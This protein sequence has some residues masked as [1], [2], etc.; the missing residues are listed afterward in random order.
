MTIRYRSIALALMLHLLLMAE[1]RFLS[2]EDSAAKDPSGVVDVVSLDETE[3]NES[4]GLAL[5]RRRQNHFWSHNDSGAKA[6]LYAFDS[7]GRK[8]GQIK[9][10][11]EE[12]VDWEDMASFTDHGVPRLLVA[13]CGD[14]QANRASITLHLLD[15][16]D[17]TRSTSPKHT[18]TISVTYPDGPRDC[19]AVAV[20]PYRRQIVL[21]SKAKLPAAGVYVIP[22]PERV[23]KSTQATV[24]ARRIGTLPLPMVTAMDIHQPSGDI[25]VVSYFHAFRFRCAARNV[26]IAR[27]LT[28]LP[29]S[30]ELPRWK[31]IESVAVDAE[32][33]IW[34]T[35]EGSPA[36]LGRLPQ[37]ESTRR[38]RPRP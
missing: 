11:S 31:Q 3:L 25:W 32:N 8:T 20:D 15:E 10:K 29:E 21:I 27:Q 12:S 5:S 37:N 9:L 18:Q 30:H 17:P 7:R 38:K 1:T 28:L 4:S 33:D 16:P 24:M 6:R 22:L 2:A 13:D 14:N 34:V 26:S 19:E 35:S 36:P 23:T